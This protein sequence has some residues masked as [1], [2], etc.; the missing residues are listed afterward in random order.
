MLLVFIANENKKIAPP[1][2]HQI[3]CIASLTFSTPISLIRFSSFS[4]SRFDFGIRQL[5][6]PILIAS[7]TLWAA[8]ETPLTSPERPTSP[9]IS[10]PGSTSRFLKLDTSAITTARSRAG[11]FIFI[12]PAIFT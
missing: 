9:K 4:F 5:V 12:P 8:W 6:K 7:D 10:I 1:S 2:Q 11:S 3:N